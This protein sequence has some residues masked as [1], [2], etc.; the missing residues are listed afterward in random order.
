MNC[1][2]Y[3]FTMNTQLIQVGTNVMCA[4]VIHIEHRESKEEI[5]KCCGSRGAY[6]AGCY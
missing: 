3:I 4:Y 2:A 6:C 1:N 5:K